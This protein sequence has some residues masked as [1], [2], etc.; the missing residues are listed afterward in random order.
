MTVI[1]PERIGIDVGW[2]HIDMVLV[3]LTATPLARY[4]RDFAYLDAKTI[5]PE[6][7]AAL[8]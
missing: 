6:L 8:G 7:M 3:D 2:Q 5:V 4:R 1:P